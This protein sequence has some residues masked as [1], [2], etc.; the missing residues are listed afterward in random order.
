MFKGFLLVNSVSEVPAI[1][2]HVVHVNKADGK[3]MLVFVKV[4]KLP[5]GCKL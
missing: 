1:L 5:L 4:E 3:E 2:S